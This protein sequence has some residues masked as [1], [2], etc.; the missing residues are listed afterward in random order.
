MDLEVCAEH[1]RV[2]PAESFSSLADVED[3]LR[4]VAALL[5]GQLSGLRLGLYISRQ[6]VELHGGQIRAEFPSDG[7]TRFTVR[8]QR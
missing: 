7:G 2:V 4:A 3:C 6:I 5:I 8:L 1:S